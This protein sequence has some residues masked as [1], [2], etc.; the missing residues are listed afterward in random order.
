MKTTAQTIANASQ[1][2]A[3]SGFQE[4]LLLDVWQVLRARWFW[5]YSLLFG[6]LVVVLFTMGVTES[7]IIG[8]V[9]LS[10]LMVTFIQICIAIIPIFVLI[11]TVRSVVGERETLVLEYMLSLPVSFKEYFWGKFTGR[12]IVVFFPVFI[13]LLGAVLWGSIKQLEIPWDLFSLY[14]FLLAAMIIYFLGL[15]MFLSTIVRSQEMGLSLGFVIW[16]LMVAFL[17]II[18]LGVMLK[19]HIDPGV[20]IGAA[21]LNPLQVFRTAAMALFDPKLTVLGPASYY[22]LD[23]V[24]RG[25]FIAFAVLYPIISGLFW[26][27]LGYWFFSRTDSI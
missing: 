5:G 3:T 26:A 4:I 18:L 12:F 17:D 27:W 1:Q 13:S 24:G 25:M 2:T 10:R 15:G 11:T 22:I 20:V 9:G 19:T 21:M 6:G 23:T 16:I 14:S 8:F 7:Q